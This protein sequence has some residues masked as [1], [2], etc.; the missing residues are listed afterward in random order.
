MNDVARVGQ[1]VERTTGVVH[2]GRHGVG[3]K[4]KVDLVVLPRAMLEVEHLDGGVPGKLPGEAHHP[5]VRRGVGV[6]RQ[7]GDQHPSTRR[8]QLRPPPR[9]RVHDM[10]RRRAG[11]VI[12]Q[13]VVAAVDDGGHI[14]AWE[15]AY[16]WGLHRGRAPSAPTLRASTVAVA[17]S[18]MV[19]L[20]ALASSHHGR[21]AGRCSWS[22][23]RTKAVHEQLQ[24]HN[25]RGGGSQ[26][27]G[28][29]T[30]LR[31]CSGGATC[32]GGKRA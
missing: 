20:A 19:V 9:G 7:Y 6:E 3:F 2:G 10:E 16:V 15:E 24:W 27:G 8:W 32:G 12:E 5:I 1:H 11:C 25:G 4:V 26:G 23:T 22:T 29:A 28:I 17:I 21:H 31:T 30:E 18:N 14:V 13:Q